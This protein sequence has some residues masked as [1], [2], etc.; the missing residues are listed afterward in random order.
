MKQPD[1]VMSRSFPTKEMIQQLFSA[2]A[3]A[4]VSARTQN[5]MRSM[6]EHPPRLRL[7]INLKMFLTVF[8][9]RAETNILIG[10]LSDKERQALCELD[11][12]N[13][14][15]PLR[16]V[17]HGLLNVHERWKLQKNILQ[18]MKQAEAAADH[19]VD[20]GPESAIL[21]SILGSNN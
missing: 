17:A 19:R 6:A 14:P 1:H 3:R 18:S 10:G 11:S 8:E 20:G 13:L 9:L 12:A 15:V 5:L 21:D 16:E 7:V 2:M 4:K